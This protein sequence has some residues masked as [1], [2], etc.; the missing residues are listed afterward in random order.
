MPLHHRIKKKIVSS[1]PVRGVIHHS[2][3]IYV[4]GF[5][6]LTLFHVWAPFILQLRKGSLFE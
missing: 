5:G 2:K 4:P 6:D 1:A 3:N